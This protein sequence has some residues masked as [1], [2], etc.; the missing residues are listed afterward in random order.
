MQD[1]RAWHKR[2][3]MMKTQDL[4]PIKTDPANLS[5]RVEEQ[6]KSFPG[7]KSKEMYQHQACIT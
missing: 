7:K 2:V 6:I 3:D 4:Q 1:K 5:F